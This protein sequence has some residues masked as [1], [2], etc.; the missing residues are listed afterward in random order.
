MIQQ[1]IH[2]MCRVILKFLYLKDQF[3]LNLKTK[4]IYFYN[5]GIFEECPALPNCTEGP[6]WIPK[7]N[8]FP[9][10]VAKVKPV[11]SQRK[12]DLLYLKM[13]KLFFFLENV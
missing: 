12:T 3:N 5:Y 6:N 9:K 4:L 13:N 2:R 1:Q 10:L 8:I 11:I 7:L